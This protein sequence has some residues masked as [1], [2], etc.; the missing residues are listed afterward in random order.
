MTQVALP[1]AARDRLLERFGPGTAAWLDGFGAHV[2][3]LCRQWELEPGPVHVGGTGAVVQCRSTRD[4]RRYGL[5]LTP[6][7]TVAGQEGAAL[8]YWAEAPAVVDLVAAD[9]GRGALLLEWLPDATVLGGWQ[10]RE[11]AALI[12]DLYPE[13]HDARGGAPPA[14]VPS[15]SERLDT[16]FDLWDRRRCA[17]P[18]SP[19][20]DA[21]WA[22]CR[23]A[24]LAMADHGTTLLHGDLH[25]GNILRAGQGRGLVAIDP[26]PC[27]GDPAMDLADLAMNGPGGAAGIRGRCQELAA[28]AAA[29]DADRLWRWCRNFAPLMAVSRAHA[30]GPRLGQFPTYTAGSARRTVD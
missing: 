12:G 7:R 28:L 25:A 27:L 8:T 4:G 30:R 17:L 6:D 21:D 29:V 3:E 26:R 14:T 19:V 1:P 18:E 22:R 2:G 23:D 24:A 5:K 11:L 9:P 16:V 20:D 15:A 13:G 10:V